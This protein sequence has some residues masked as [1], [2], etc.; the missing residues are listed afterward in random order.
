MIVWGKKDRDPGPHVSA[1]A[2]SLPKSWGIR[3]LMELGMNVPNSRGGLQLI[4]FN[5]FQQKTKLMW[6]HKFNTRRLLVLM[7]AEHKWQY[8]EVQR[9]HFYGV[10]AFGGSEYSCWICTPRGTWEMPK[11][12]F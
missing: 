3:G 6:Q 9:V 2:Q 5:R 7:I 1:K 8:S 12:D 4:I 10:G 11:L